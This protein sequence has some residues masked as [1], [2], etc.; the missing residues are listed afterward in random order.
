[1]VR[2]G[3]DATDARHDD[4]HLLS[5]STLDEEFKTAKFHRLKVR[6][7]GCQG[8]RRPIYQNR[9]N[10]SRVALQMGHTAGGCSRAQ[11]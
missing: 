10:L 3:T 11:R 6:G 1:M 7:E 4:G 9:S 2:R 5:R 8:L